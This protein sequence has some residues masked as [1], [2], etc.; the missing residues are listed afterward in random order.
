M[1]DINRWKGEAK[2]RKAT[3]IIVVCDTFDYSNYPVYVQSGDELESM[4]AR[5]SQNMDRVMEVIEL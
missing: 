3:H 5:Y 2:R 4:K 1:N